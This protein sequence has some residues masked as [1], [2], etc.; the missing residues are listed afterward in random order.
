MKTRKIITLLLFITIMFCTFLNV[1]LTET[2]A[3]D[4]A[5]TSVCEYKNKTA[6]ITV[7]KASVRTSP[8]DSAKKVTILNYKQKL[9][10]KDEINGWYKVK[11]S[12]GEIGYIKSEYVSTQKPYTGYI[13]VKKVAA[14]VKA[15][16]SAK[17][18]TTLSYNQKVKVIYKENG[19]I[20]IRTSSGKIAYV[21]EK[22]V[23][24]VKAQ[25]GYIIAE[26]VAL[27]VNAKNTAKKVTILSS[28]NKV[29]IINETS[30]WY[31]VMTSNG[32]IG[33]VKKMYVSKLKASEKKIAYVIKEESLRTKPEDGAKKVAILPYTQELKI[34]G[35]SDS[36]YTVKTTTG[37]IGYIKTKYIST[38]KPYIERKGY[39]KTNSV[40]NLNGL[41]QDNSSR[42]ATLSPGEIVTIIGEQNGWYKV[43]K[44]SGQEG[45]IKIGLVSTREPDQSVLLATYTTYSKGSPA[46]RNYNIAR[47]CS[48]VNGTILRP[49]E[50]FNWFTVVGSCGKGNG[51]R[52]ATVIVNGKYLQDYGGGVC[53]VATT[54]CGCAKNLN[55][56]NIYARPHSGHVSY[57]N[58]DGV[59]AAVSYGSKNFKFTNTTNKTI[60]IE[61][62]S[63]SGR[64]IIAAYEIK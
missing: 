32:K 47:A 5:T 53:Q 21:K 18:V 28:E 36:W 44:S 34:L 3:T 59:E 38:E 49:G 40:T 11:I 16:D 13:V 50:T 61:T 15:K 24:T 35:E 31:K 20:T 17:K 9:V 26:N 54:L 25:K 64:I 46:N 14:R 1:T 55:I 33:Y 6:Y 48:K 37:K 12:S 51:Y 42:V 41:P 58:G 45:Y 39:V 52:T 57:L 63:S 23:S 27:R 56:K 10:I 19:W 2:Y 22:Y 62:Y 43:R 60:Q 7:N 30:Q 8:K 29:T 4:S